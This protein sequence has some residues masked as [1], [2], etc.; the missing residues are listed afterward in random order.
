MNY[1]N[2]I[3]LADILKRGFANNKREYDFVKWFYKN[4]INKNYTFF[5]ELKT[6][7]QNSNIK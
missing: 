2:E 6:C 4:T 7:L 5:Q 1:M 3:C